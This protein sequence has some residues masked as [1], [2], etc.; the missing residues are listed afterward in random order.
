MA[1]VD[2]TDGTSAIPF[3]GMDKEYRIK[4]R[5]NF[6]VRNVTTADTV[7]V[8]MV[9][10]NTHVKKVYTKV[11]TPEGAAATCTIGDAVDAD[12][13]DA[14]VDLNAAA[15]SITQSTSADAY[16]NGKIYT[17]ETN[18]TLVPVNDLSAAVIDVYVTCEDLN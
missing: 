9:K 3:N 11:I 17:T 15:G 4:N 10:A 13:F 8:L 6:G 5:L 16:A 7:N 2:L 14:D 18:I 1:T 12:G